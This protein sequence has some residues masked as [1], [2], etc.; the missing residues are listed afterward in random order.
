MMFSSTIHDVV[1]CELIENAH[2]RGTRGQYYATTL[3]VTS[4]VSRSDPDGPTVSADVV[5]FSPEP[6]GLKKAK[7]VASD[8]EKIAAVRA[9]A[10]QHYDAGGWDIVIECWSDDDILE[11]AQG[12][13]NELGAIAKVRHA[14]GDINSVREDIRSA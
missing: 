12:A 7:P 2:E 1:S 3:R 13:R 14:V 10:A 4:L 5:L 11:A 9:Y 8:V 6:L